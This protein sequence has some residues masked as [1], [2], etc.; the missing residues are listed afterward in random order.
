MS[1]EFD[2]ISRTHRGL[3]GRQAKAGVPPAS[4]GAASPIAGRNAPTR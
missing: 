4:F 1:E 2:A 3:D